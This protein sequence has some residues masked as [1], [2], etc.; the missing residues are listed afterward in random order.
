MVVL[1]TNN[2]FRAATTN[3]E[4]ECLS[5]AQMHTAGHTQGDEARLFKP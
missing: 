2:H 1:G 5:L 3:V 4:E